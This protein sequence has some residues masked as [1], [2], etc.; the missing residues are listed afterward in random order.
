MRVALIIVAQML[1]SALVVLLG[2]WSLRKLDRML[3]QGDPE[4][5]PDEI[6]PYE[7]GFLT[8]GE[9]VVIVVAVYKLLKERLLRIVTTPTAANRDMKA[10][11]AGEGVSAPAGSSAIDIAVIEYFRQERT[12][13]TALEMHLPQTIHVF[14]QPYS[15]FLKAQ[16]LLAPNEAFAFASKLRVLGALVMLAAAAYAT[17]AMYAV[18]PDLTPS[19]LA[20]GMGALACLFRMCQVRRATRRGEAFLSLLRRHVLAP[21]DLSLA[22][23]SERAAATM[24]LFGWNGLYDPADAEF[25]SLVLLSGAGLTTPSWSDSRQPHDRDC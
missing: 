8:G 18:R 4:P 20:I 19:T 14:C 10:I 7:V 25:R 3:S 1:V 17:A 11:V 15:L 13:S 16:R 22:P 6:D 9:R 21:R 24:A 23:S 5:D 2:T 12:L